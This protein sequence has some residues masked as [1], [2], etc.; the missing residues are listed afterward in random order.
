[1]AADVVAHGDRLTKDKAWLLVRE[2]FGPTL[3]QKAFRD[4]VWPA[5]APALWKARG[6]PKMKETPT[7]PQPEK[8]RIGL[9]KRDRNKK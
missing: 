6:R 3:S 8:Y 1:L 5:A 7:P 2:K 4:R 9:V